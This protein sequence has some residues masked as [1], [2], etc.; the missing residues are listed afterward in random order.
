MVEEV[1]RIIYNTLASG[2]NMYITGIGSLV[3]EQSSAKRRT[4]KSVEQP[5]KTIVFTEQQNGVSLEEEI[6]RIGNIDAEQAHG[7]FEQWLAQVLDSETLVIEG[8]GTLRR[9][10]FTITDS[11]DE[12]LN[13]QGSEQITVKTCRNEGLCIFASLCGI[14]ALCLAGYVWFEMRSGNISAPFNRNTN[15]YPVASVN[16]QPSD[17]LAT[18]A[19][20]EDIINVAAATDGS[21]DAPTVANATETSTAAEPSHDKPAEKAVAADT[22][23]KTSAATAQAST[24]K[25]NGKIFNSVSG[26]SYVVIGVYSTPENAFRA[27]EQAKQ[28][29]S[30]VNCTVY[31]YSSKYMVSVYNSDNREQAVAYKNRISRTFE[32]LWIYTK[33]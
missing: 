26:R 7:I 14:L 19:P 6:A 10:E 11:F 17:A 5:R 4:R 28:R 29:M 9:D 27:V 8:V 18:N 12:V 24:G 1:N 25:S 31:Y 22:N 16:E 2:E 33:K 20:N 15:D 30:D 23:A 32:G 13:K 3:I 21:V